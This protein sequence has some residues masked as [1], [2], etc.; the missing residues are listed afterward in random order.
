[1]V[2]IYYDVIHIIFN[3]LVFKMSTRSLTY[4][5]SVPQQS[6]TFLGAL[7]T[8]WLRKPAGIDVERNY[9]TITLCTHTH[10]HTHTHYVLNWQHLQIFNCL[11]QRDLF[12]FLGITVA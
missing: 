7:P 6:K 12:L 5:Q 4:R 8:R 11:A 1:M 2:K 3:R 10:A 9:V